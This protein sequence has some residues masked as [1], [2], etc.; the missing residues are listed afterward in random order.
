MSSIRYQIMPLIETDEDTDI[1]IY[2]LFAVAWEQFEFNE[3]I[4]KHNVN[5]NDTQKPYYIAHKYYDDVQYEDLL[6]LINNIEDPSELT[7]FTTI[8]IPEMKDIDDFILKYV[9]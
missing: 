3:G 7:T 4:T 5:K 9:D 6:F 2:D 1:E 8:D